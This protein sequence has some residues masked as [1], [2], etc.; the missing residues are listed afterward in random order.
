LAQQGRNFRL[1]QRP[2]GGQDG[3][4]REPVL[5]RSGEQVRAFEE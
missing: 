5:Q 3:E 2:L 1:E 4:R